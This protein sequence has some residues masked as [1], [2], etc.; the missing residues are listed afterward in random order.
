MSTSVV[1]N[2]LII[3]EDV[4]IKH[5]MNQVSHPCHLHVKLGCYEVSLN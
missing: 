5:K 3:E 4:D 1:L 2:I